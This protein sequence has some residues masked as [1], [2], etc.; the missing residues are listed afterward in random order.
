MFFFRLWHP[1]HPD[2]RFGPQVHKPARPQIPRRLG[3]RSPAARARCSW[4][5]PGERRRTGTLACAPPVEYADRSI[6]PRRLV[7]AQT[8][9]AWRATVSVGEGPK[10]LSRSATNSFLDLSPVRDRLLLAVLAGVFSE[11]RADGQDARALEGVSVRQEG[12]RLAMKLLP[13]FIA[14]LVLYVNGTLPPR[15]I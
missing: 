14:R 8:S 3:Q 4:R 12:G 7:L 11:L 5:D 15:T 9:P 13:S 6:S 10:I 2:T 1:P